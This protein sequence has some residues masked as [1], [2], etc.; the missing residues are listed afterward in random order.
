MTVGHKAGHY[1]HFMVLRSANSDTGRKKTKGKKEK[2]S[3]VLEFMGGGGGDTFDLNVP[4]VGT[5]LHL[6]F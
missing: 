2:K 1:C 4:R 6:C 5:E 3:R